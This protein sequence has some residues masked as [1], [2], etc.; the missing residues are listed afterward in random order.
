MGRGAENVRCFFPQT[1]ILIKYFPDVS[2]GYR[3]N[4]HFEI[5]KIEMSNI[6]DCLAKIEIF[7][8]QG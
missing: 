7:W 4:N 1:L 8:R 6:T 5:D 2:K 3:I